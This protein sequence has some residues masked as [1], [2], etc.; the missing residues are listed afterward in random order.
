M[1]PT[2]FTIVSGPSSAELFAACRK[3]ARRSKLSLP[4]AF[5]TLDGMSLT[6]VIQFLVDGVN[7]HSYRFRGACSAHLLGDDAVPLDWAPCSGTY[8]P[9]QQSGT[10]L[11]E[12]PN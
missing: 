4:C 12:S 6:V 2:T 5:Q 10:L 3:Q 11:L 1:S 9:D 7:H 8:R